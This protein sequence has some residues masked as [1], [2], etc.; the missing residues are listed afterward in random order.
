MVFSA[1]SILTLLVTDQIYSRK[2]TYETKFVTFHLKDAEG[3]CS[4]KENSDEY[5]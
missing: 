5:F 3:M 4:L 2:V 1:F